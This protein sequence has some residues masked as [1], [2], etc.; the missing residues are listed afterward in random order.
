ME[1]SKIPPISGLQGVAL[2]DHTIGKQNPTLFATIAWSIWN[3]YNKV[4]LA[5][6]TCNLHQL[7]QVLKDRFEKF[8]ALQ[9]PQA[10]PQQ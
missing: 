10:L 3:Q 8:L 2:L 5:Q 6:S 4:H 7:A 9:T 1:F